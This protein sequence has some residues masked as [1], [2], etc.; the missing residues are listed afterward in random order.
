M[1]RIKEK[2]CKNLSNDELM[3]HPMAFY[4][5]LFSSAHNLLF[6]AAR[7]GLSNNS[8]KFYRDLMENDFPKF[9]QFAL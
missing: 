1:K 7:G 3:P 2:V 6:S 9:C 8:N 5:N 4:F